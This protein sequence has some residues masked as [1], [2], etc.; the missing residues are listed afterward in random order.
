MGIE[1]INQPCRMDREPLIH[2]GF[3]SLK[4]WSENNVRNLKWVSAGDLDLSS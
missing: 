2:R 3:F 4:V 1:G